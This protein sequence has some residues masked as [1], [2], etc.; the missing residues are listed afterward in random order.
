MGTLLDAPVEALVNTVNTV[1][2]MGK[3]IALQF[4]RAYP[5]MFKDYAAA[6]KRNELA[7]GRMHVWHTG[8]LEGP[9]VMINFPTKR[10]WRG[11][12]RLPD[13][14]AGLKDLIEVIQ[15]E[16]IRS[17]A[18]PP[19]GCG[20]GGLNWADVE[21]LIRAKMQGLKD[22]DVRIYPPVGTA[23]AAEMRSASRSRE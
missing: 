21:P 12:S 6:A 9:R 16:R 19:L 22:V 18:V 11:G 3:G 13:I 2:V 7:L 14:E 1:G 4:K 23:A 15:R 10:H 20:H 5:A 8:K 17:I